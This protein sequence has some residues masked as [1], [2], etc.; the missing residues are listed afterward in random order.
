MQQELYVFRAGLLGQGHSNLWKI[1]MTHFIW[2]FQSKLVGIDATFHKSKQAK[3]LLKMCL[4]T[5]VSKY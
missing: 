1:C 3:T 5:K 4:E 2:L